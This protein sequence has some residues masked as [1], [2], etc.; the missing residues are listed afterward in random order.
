MFIWEVITEGAGREEE[1]EMGELKKTNIGYISKL[2]TSVG[3][4]VKSHNRQWEIV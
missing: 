1:N 4:E 2:V 3:D